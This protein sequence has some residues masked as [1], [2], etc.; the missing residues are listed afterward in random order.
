MYPL[1]F[2]DGVRFKVRDGGKIMNKVAYIALGINQYGLKEIL[3]IWISDTEGIKFWHQV[4]TEIKNR[5]VEDIFFVCVDGLTG[6][7][8]AIETVFP[9]AEIQSCIVHQMRNSMK[10][11]KHKDKEKFCASLKEIHMA[12]T[13]EAGFAALER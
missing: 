11:V 7:P 3:G 4:L 13:E 5:G 10:Y 1:V 12:V 2:L 6:F 9:K 8:E